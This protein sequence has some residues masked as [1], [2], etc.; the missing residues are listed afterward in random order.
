MSP[1]R[2]TRDGEASPTPPIDIRAV[3]APVSDQPGEWRGKRPLMTHE[4]EALALVLERLG[5]DHVRAHDLTVFLRL[6]DPCK[7]DGWRQARQEAYVQAAMA[8]LDQ[9]LWLTRA[10]DELSQAQAEVSE[11]TV[12]RMVFRVSLLQAA[13]AFFVTGLPPEEVESILAT[14]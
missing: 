6:I 12:D 9:P 3:L 7:R 4:S 10:L 11:R 1:L 13:I 2:A 8:S 5:Q 14:G